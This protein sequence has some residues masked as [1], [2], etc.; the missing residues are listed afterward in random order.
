MKKLI[1]LFLNFRSQSLT[2]ICDLQLL[3]LFVYK[4]Y[5][6]TKKFIYRRFLTLFTQWKAFCDFLRRYSKE[7][8]GWGIA[9][10][11]KFC[12]FVD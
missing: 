2:V 8:A 4:T 6:N 1:N 10:C 12:N 9:H 11:A 3:L 5:E 7:N